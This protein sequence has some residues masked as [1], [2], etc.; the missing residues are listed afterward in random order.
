MAQTS[1]RAHAAAGQRHR[2]RVT[3]AC[4]AAVTACGNLIHDLT[5]ALCLIEPDMREGL[6]QQLG[7]S[8][9]VALQRLAG[10]HQDRL[11]LLFVGDLTADVG[12]IVHATA[13]S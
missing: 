6:C 10:Q 5:Q 7:K 9:V 8:L 1:A 4:N 11:A 2:Q 12:I 3:L 13:D